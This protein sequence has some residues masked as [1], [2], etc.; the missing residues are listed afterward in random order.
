MCCLIY[1]EGQIGVKL[2]TWYVGAFIF[3]QEVDCEDR[4]YLENKYFFPRSKLFHVRLKLELLV[5]VN[6]FDTSIFDMI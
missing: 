2:I 6:K 3:Q 1:F 4:N 5:K